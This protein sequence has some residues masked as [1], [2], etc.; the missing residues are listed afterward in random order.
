MPAMTHSAKSTWAWGMSSTK[1]R[2]ADLG[3]SPRA[4]QAPCAPTVK[5]SAS[6]LRTLP[7]ATEPPSRHV[8]R[9]PAAS[10]PGYRRRHLLSSAHHH[11]DLPDNETTFHP[12]RNS[13][14][15]HSCQP[16]A[17]TRHRALLAG[18]RHMGFVAASSDRALKV[19]RG[20]LASFHQNGIKPQ[21]AATSSRPSSPK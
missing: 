9:L 20:G 7:P 1:A 3:R 17:G 8:S 19:R 16:I 21:R 5:V 12:N 2:V 11:L 4:L 6:C 13:D 14:S 18:C 15:C 10:C